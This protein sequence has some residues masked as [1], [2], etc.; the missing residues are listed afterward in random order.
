[1]SC[2]AGRKIVG[3]HSACAFCP[4]AAQDRHLHLGRAMVRAA[5]GALRVGRDPGAVI[6]ASPERWKFMRAGGRRL[7]A[8]LG[9]QQAGTDPRGQGLW[10]VEFD[11][12]R[13]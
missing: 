4:G 9:W 12:L 6:L 11:P 3:V 2:G 13:S 5:V 7:L 10:T 1:L 8:H